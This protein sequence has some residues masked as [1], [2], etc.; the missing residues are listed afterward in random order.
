M[1]ISQKAVAEF[2]QPP[3]P[4]SRFCFYFGFKFIYLRAVTEKSAI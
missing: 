4:L 1:V 3:F 2:F